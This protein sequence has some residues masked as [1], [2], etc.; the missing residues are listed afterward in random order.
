MKP[1]AALQDTL[2][3]EMLGHIKQTDDTVPYAR[4]RLLLLLANARR[5]P[6]SDLLSQ[7][8]RPDAPE[9]V[10]LDQNELA[11]G[12][13]S[14][15]RSAPA[16]S[17]TTGTSWRS[18]WTTPATGST[19]CG[20]RTC[21]PA[22]CCPTRSSAWTMSRG[23]PTTRRCS[24]SPKT[25]SRSATTS[26]G[27]TSSAQ[28]RASSSTRR[29]TSCSISLPSLARQGHRLSRSRRR[30][31]RRKCGTCR[32]IAPASAPSAHRPA[33]RPITNTTSTTAAVSSTSAPTKA[34]RTSASSPR[35][36]RDPSETELEGARRA[37]PAV[38][39]EDVDLFAD[40]AVLSEWENGLQQIESR[41]SRD[42]AR[43]A[44]S[45]IPEPVY[46]ASLG[47]EHGVRHDDAS[48]RLSVARHAASVVD[49]DMDTGT[50]DA[51]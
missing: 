23:R 4:E 33:T 48:L 30:R 39:I 14:S 17:A 43:G 25:P 13:R 11:Q 51:C 20:S 6:V 21:G 16:A 50:I 12:T 19:R 18:R 9:E 3:Q 29:R 41:R 22:S 26:S 37:R 38:K 47:A 10:I 34:R 44:G 35:R 7:A 46:A 42:A 5:P 8:R 36:S 49:Y 2:Y 27:G 31:R 1:T 40:H 15:S 45:S 24:T 28:T 32:L